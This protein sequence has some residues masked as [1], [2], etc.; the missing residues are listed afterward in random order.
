M[1]LEVSIIV[2]NYRAAEF[3]LGCVDSILAGDAGGVE[4]IVVDNSSTQAETERL[5]TL[6]NRGVKLIFNAGNPGFAKACN[7]GV[8]MSSGKYI[9]FL[10]PDTIV[11]DGCVRRLVDYLDSA[12]DAG[13]VGP[14]T[15][16]DSARTIQLIQQH[17]P[18]PYLS[19]IESLSG[20]RYL[21]RT[22]DRAIL[23]RDYL[24]SSTTTPL[25]VQMLPGSAILTSRAILQRVGLFDEDYPLYFEDSDW[26]RRL[27]QS[28]LNLYMVPDAQ[29]CHFYNQSAR[30]DSGGA[31]GKFA[32]SAERYMSRHHS[33]MSRLA[34]THISRVANR[35]KANSPLPGLIDLGIIG[36]SPIFSSNKAVSGRLLFQLSVNTAFL[37][38]AIALAYKPEFQLPQE[39]W[40]YLCSG[41]YY[42]R[43]VQL[44]PYKTLDMW[45]FIRE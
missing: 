20:L 33:P 18:S 30:T 1:E 12:R 35:L 23:R 22:I 24:Y 31:S 27:R 43:L 39:V 14:R 28:G 21:H 37:P 15:W 25:S 3:V 38:S 45:Q 10:N 34:A 5:E 44:Q 32:A 7:Q 11:F 17:L 41:V 42:A 8:N 9:M 36:H 29:I 16:W 2:V 6:A 4:V 40:S 19:I 26:C 13:A